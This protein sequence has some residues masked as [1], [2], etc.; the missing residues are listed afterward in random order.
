[1]KFCSHCFVDEE[2]RPIIE[3]L[4]QIESLCPVCGKRNAFIY[5][6][7]VNSEL[8][9]SFETLLE[10]YTPGSMLPPDFPAEEKSL[11]VAELS[12]RWHIFNAKLNTTDVYRIIKALCAEKYESIPSLFDSPVGIAELNDEEFFKGHSLLRSDSWRDFVESVKSKNRFHTNHINL[13]ILERY[14]SFIRKVYK[15][16]TVFFRSRVSSEEGFLPKDMD[17]P[18]SERATAGRANSAGIRCLYLASDPKTTIHEI[19][20]GAFDY[21][22]VGRFELKE[23]I[24]IVD[25]KT[26]DHISPFIEGLEPKEHAINKEHLK[27]INVEIGRAL[28]R[29]DSVLDYIPTQY[30]ADFIKSILY[31]GKPE[32]SG[33]E[34]NSTLNLSGQN[35]AVFYPELFICTDVEVYHIKELD[36]KYE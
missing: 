5:D 9:E 14:C 28:R 25:L 17:A 31:E 21:V 2:L 8:I 6:T 18:P 33:I 27:R 32:Y 10:I 30:I 24:V 15:K 4:R 36:Y 35:L 3:G 16:G 26:I 19:R 23:D 11:L 22:S 29:S 34:Y 20:A 13:P 1:M 7:N 12:D